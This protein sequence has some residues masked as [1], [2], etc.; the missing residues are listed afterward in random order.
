MSNKRNA[1][2]DV[3][4]TRGAVIHEQSTTA[5]TACRRLLNVEHKA[6]QM[7]MHVYVDWRVAAAGDDRSD[8]EN[9]SL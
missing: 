4:N 3:T 6:K 2:T 7:H 9:M 1:T 5:H 8:R